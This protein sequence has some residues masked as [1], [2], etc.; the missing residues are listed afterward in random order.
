M[1]K[2]SDLSDY[3]VIKKLASALYQ[4]DASQHGAAIMIGAGFTR[5]AALHVGGV[6]KMPLWND[7]SKG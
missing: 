2:I 4:F 3:P 6:K 5:S 7:F 1:S